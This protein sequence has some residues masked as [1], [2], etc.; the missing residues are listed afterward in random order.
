MGTK[1]GETGRSSEHGRRV[2]GDE[3]ATEQPRGPKP[4]TARETAFLQ[5]Y[6]AGQRDAASKATRQDDALAEYLGE[7]EKG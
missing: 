4:R 2:A 6:Q 3:G 5:G 7:A 1:D